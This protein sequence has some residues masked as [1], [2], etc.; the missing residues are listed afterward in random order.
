MLSVSGTVCAALLD[1]ASLVL[2]ISARRMRCAHANWIVLLTTLFFK[3]L[4]ADS[5][6]E[7]YSVGKLTTLAAFLAT[8]LGRRRK[9]V[10][11]H[12]SQRPPPQALLAEQRCGRR[13][14]Y[15]KT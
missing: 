3:G 15:R 4:V 10:S 7:K 2:G 14:W 13:A 8:F 11:L 1:F 9:C 5:E 6:G 12:P